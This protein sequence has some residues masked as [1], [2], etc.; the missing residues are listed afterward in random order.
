[1]NKVTDSEAEILWKQLGIDKIGD[2]ILSRYK[3]YG[4][5]SLLFEH[6]GDN[7]LLKI[8]KVIPRKKKV[9]I[10]IK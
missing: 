9:K 10:N 6:K 3:E 2:S 8:S 5:A 4:L 1:M 7:Y